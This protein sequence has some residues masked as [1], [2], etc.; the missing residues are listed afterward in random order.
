MDTSSKTPIDENMI[1]VHPI[2][3]DSTEVA[4]YDIPVV[5]T[6]RDDTRNLFNFNKLKL[7]EKPNDSPLVDDS[8]PLSLKDCVGYLP[9]LPL[10]APNADIKKPQ[11]IVDIVNIL[12]EPAAAAEFLKAQ[13]TREEGRPEGSPAR[14]FT[15]TSDLMKKMSNT[16]KKRTC[17]I[18]APGGVF[19]H[20]VDPGCISFYKKDGLTFAAT[21]GRWI[22]KSIKA[23]WI[24]KNVSLDNDEIKPFD[25]KVLI[26]RVL[27]GEIGLVREQGTEM[28]LDVGTHVF[29]SG[30]VSLTKKVSY[31]ENTNFSHGRY[32]YLRVQRG[33]YG[34]VWVEVIKDGIKALVPRLLD[35][36]EHYVDSHL[37][38]FN[39][40]VKSSDAVVEHGSINRI[41]VPKGKV[42]K[43]FQETKP[44]L[45][46]EGD[47][48]I[49][50]TDF[51]YVGM[52]D[53]MNNNCIQHGTITIF[54]VTLGKLALAWQES[55][56]VFIDKPGLYE[57]DSPDFSF[58]EFK[59]AEERLIQLGAKKI[60]LVHTGQ[61][62]V[63]YDE[64]T[65]KILGNGRHR[66]SKSTHIFHR[67]LSTQ[68]K[69]IRL[70]TY[71]ANE[72]MTQKTMK[73]SI[74]SNYAQENHYVKA[75]NNH[76]NADLTICETKD[77]V[78]V[79]LR[80]DVFYSIDDPEKCINKIDT[81]EL[82][83]LVRETAIA[84]LTNIIRS[85][86][87][88]QIAQSKQV[89]VGD[90]GGNSS[91]PFSSTSA[92]NADGPAPTAPM[93]VF[94]ERAHDEFM[95]K[96]HDDFMQR[97]GVDIANI[98]IESFKIMDTDLADSISKH[99][100]T[101]AQIENEMANLEGKSLISTQTER[102]AAEV[103]NIEAKADAAALKIKTDAENQR[104]IDAAL[105]EAESLK[106]NA[107]A[108]AEAE[109]EAILLQ[110]K[111]EA[112][113]IKLKANAEAERAE[114]L[115]STELGQQEALLGIY[116]DMVV[117]SNEGVEKVVYL[118]PSVNKE[119]PF[120]L[121]SL[122]NLNQDLHSLTQLGVATGEATRNLNAD[123]TSRG[124]PKRGGNI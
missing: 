1:D 80:A 47:H 28:L 33:W 57:F 24:E 50:S 83:D 42:A 93:A 86:A 69:S 16:A 121:S 18:K 75:S 12:T 38:Q 15:P 106:I 123:N 85:T 8:I 48:F 4:E 77:L 29:N 37:F 59:D 60:V 116:A 67:F 99:A 87:L 70:A 45:L 17:H 55:D 119:S 120:A 11:S 64:G 114:M 84:T 30:T 76:D 35:Q 51:Q 36:G 3:A 96:L 103:K 19:G 23:S 90:P 94:F 58:V 113:A 104:R 73:K 91:I 62:G 97:Y 89:S 71:N 122:H 56:P 54:R 25:S 82:E 117:K 79:G 44:R 20:V 2:P 46:G 52:E 21:E 10:K 32:H 108:K 49:E 112:E 5:K 34:K 14:I 41:S 118:D 74:G 61:V 102:T 68:Q 9:N 107:R 27:P 13:L 95:V 63:T 92:S 115:A 111:A 72:K 6:L 7:I 43:V 26:V 40:F 109:A 100:L 53:I 105:A 88:N 81:D 39:G 98:R 110:A 22:L 78:K 101:T 124:A 65:L 66:I 31:A